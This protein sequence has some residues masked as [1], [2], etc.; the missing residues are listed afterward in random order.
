MKNMGTYS[1]AKKGEIYIAKVRFSDDSTVKIRPLLVVF[2]EQSDD[3]VV[4]IFITSQSARTVFDVSISAWREAGLEK[5]SIVRTSKP[6]TYHQS[7]LLKK[8]GELDEKDL[9][10]VLATFRELIS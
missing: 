3:D 6:G 5:P 9:K 4:G 2:V 1:K 7:R 10:K 8:I